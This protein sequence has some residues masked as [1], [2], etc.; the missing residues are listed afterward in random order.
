MGS[1]PHPPRNIPRCYQDRGHQ[2]HSDRYRWSTETGEWGARVRNGQ[3]HRLTAPS[4]P[5]ATQ[6]PLD[7]LMRMSPLAFIQCVIY[8]WWSGE[9]ERVRTYG[10]LEMTKG[11][12]FAL[13]INGMIAF[14]LNI[15]SFTANKKAGVSW[16]GG[17]CRLERGRL[18]E[19]VS[20][21]AAT[22]DDRL[23]QLQT[24]P[25]HRHRGRH[26]QR[27]DHTDEWDWNLVDAGGRSESCEG[28]LR[29][30][31]PPLIPLPPVFAVHRVGM[32]G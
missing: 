13:L 24:S 31:C 20:P 5:A 28:V 8:G 30:R 15:V 10:A 27:A 32:H 14:G 7:L 2:R 11:K 18:T 12:A 17:G 22:H 23:C 4:P 6:H 21:M 19:T 16:L 9:L 3:R 29:L 26:V 1:H 25:H